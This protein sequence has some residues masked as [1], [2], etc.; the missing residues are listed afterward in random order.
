MNITVEMANYPILHWVDCSL[1]NIRFTDAQ[2]SKLL[3]FN[4]TVYTFSRQLVTVCVNI[5]LP[6]TNLYRCVIFGSG[7]R[8]SS[9]SPHRVMLSSTTSVRSAIF[10]RIC[11]HWSEVH[12]SN[13]NHV[14]CLPIL[15]KSSV[16]SFM[17]FK[18]SIP[19]ERDVT[20]AIS[21]LWELQDSLGCLSTGSI[22]ILMII[23]PQMWSLIKYLFKIDTKCL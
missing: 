2:L 13:M 7:C 20:T 4:Q 18:R 3:R 16:V 8:C 15:M 23:I 9:S 21:P 22:L 10:C 17:S 5:I 11:C 1:C 19:L 14:T 12:L 6:N